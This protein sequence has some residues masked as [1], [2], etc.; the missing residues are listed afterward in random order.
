MS[1]RDELGLKIQQRGKREQ[2]GVLINVNIFR[3][4]EGGGTRELDQ[5]V[6]TKLEE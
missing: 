5:A 4:K 3:L 2:K 6:W 1:R